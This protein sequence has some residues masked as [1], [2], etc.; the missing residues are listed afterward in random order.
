MM[1]LWN[2]VEEAYNIDCHYKNRE[3]GESKLK[4][5]VKIFWRLSKWIS[6]SG[7]CFIIPFYWQLGS[8]CLLSKCSM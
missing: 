8:V 2:E 4:F 6:D 7:Y 3:M 1:N 5:K